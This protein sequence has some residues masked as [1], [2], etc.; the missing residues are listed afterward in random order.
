MVTDVAAQY[1]GQIHTIL[2]LASTNS[3][4]EERTRKYQECGA[5]VEKQARNS[6]ISVSEYLGGC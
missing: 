4:Q 6:D 2:Q 1:E 5:L 3:N